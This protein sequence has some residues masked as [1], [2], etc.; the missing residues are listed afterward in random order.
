MWFAALGSLERNDWLIH[1][2]KKILNGSEP[3]YGLLDSKQY[4]SASNPPEKIRSF[5]Y[6]YDFTLAKY[7]MLEPHRNV[8][9]SSEESS[10]KNWWRR[11]QVR[12]Y[13]PTWNLEELDSILQRNNLFQNV[14]PDRENES[15]YLLTSLDWI[16]SNIQILL[17][18]FCIILLYK[19]TI[20]L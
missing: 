9:E 16:R 17:A 10:S 8:T 18:T 15:I 7:A 1:L 2:Y 14:C 12:A 6:H 4:F 20:Y 5:L 11:T 3:V 19:E 13:S